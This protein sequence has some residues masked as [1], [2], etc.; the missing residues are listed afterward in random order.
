MTPH[1]GI[2]MHRIPV[3]GGA[4][5]LYVLGTIVV[6]LLALPQL[7]PLAALSLAGGAL[8]APALYRW[9]SRSTSLRG[10]LLLFAAGAALFVGL[11]NEVL[12]RVLAV[13]ALVAG[14][15]FAEV[16]LRRS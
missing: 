16:L 14:T 5:L 8:L 12:F 2:T 11:G 3:E 6:F 7:A 15:V 10:G 4:G 9:R 1:R 13:T